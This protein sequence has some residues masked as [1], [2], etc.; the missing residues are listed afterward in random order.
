MSIRTKVLHTTYH[1]ELYYNFSNNIF[2]IEYLDLVYKSVDNSSARLLWLFELDSNLHQF[3]TRFL[4]S[5]LDK[6]AR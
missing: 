4:F 1:R 6:M 5:D 3:V 2:T